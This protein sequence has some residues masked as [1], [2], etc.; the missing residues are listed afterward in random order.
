[1]ECNNCRKSDFKFFIK[2]KCYWSKTPLTVVMCKNCGLIFLNPRPDRILGIDYFDKAYSNANGFKNHYYYR[3]NEFIIN[4]NRE[5][6]EIL[7]KIDTPNHNILDFGAGQGHFVKICKENKW[8]ASGTEISLA[9]IKSAMEHFGIE[10]YTTLE[11]FKTKYFGIITLW[12]VIEHLENPM[13]VLMNLREYLHDDGFIIIETSNINSYD[14]LINKRKWSYWHID[15]YYYYSNIT[16]K[17]LLDSVGF[18]VI[19]FKD[20]EPNNK[21]KRIRDLKKYLILK[22]YIKAIKL[23]YYKSTVKGVSNNSLMTIVAKKKL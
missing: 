13:E 2:T 20:D 12:D 10:L 9:A 14:F 7:K 1:M 15:H 8:D 17:F 19:K 22:N 11:D 6:F 4:R 21:I 23:I 18:E 5:R 3:D 16:L